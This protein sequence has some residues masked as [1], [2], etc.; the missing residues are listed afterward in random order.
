MSAL[1]SRVSGQKGLEGNELHIP[2]IHSDLFSS[3]LILIGRAPRQE[4]C[5]LLGGKGKL[6]ATP[7]SL[8]LNISLPESGSRLAESMPQ[9]CVAAFDLQ[10]V[11]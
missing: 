7:H 6:T 3:T 4:P 8:P 9:L 5:A 10:Q 11:T 2:E 1:S